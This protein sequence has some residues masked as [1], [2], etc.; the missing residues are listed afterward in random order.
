MSLLE[1]TLWPPKWVG[2]VRFQ[3]GK[4]TEPWNMDTVCSALLLVDMNTRGQQG[5][6]VRQT[7]YCMGTVNEIVAQ[8]LSPASSFEY[9]ARSDETVLDVNE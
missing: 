9:L 2:L 8:R 4:L 7:R 6:A 1:E 5:K 3:H